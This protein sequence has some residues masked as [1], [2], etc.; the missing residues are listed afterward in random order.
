MRTHAIILA[1]GGGER[2]G[3]DVPKQFLRLAG[4]TILVRA[5]STVA[6]AGIDRLVVV[7]HPAWLDETE[8]L[9]AASRVSV[10]VKVVAGG[11]T[12]NESTLAGLSGLAAMG[13]SDDDD[14]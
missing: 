13:A 1:A 4:E 2:F 3:G 12:R 10:P 7:G 5:I 9:V 11:E 6:S 14:I 8:Q